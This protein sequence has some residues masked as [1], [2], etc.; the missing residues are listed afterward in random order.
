LNFEFLRTGAEVSFCARPIFEAALQDPGTN[1]GKV[2]KNMTE[3]TKEQKVKTER[4]K[5]KKIFKSL[6]PKA[7]QVLDGLIDNCAWM[8]IQLEDLRADLDENGTTELFQQSE[9]VDPYPRER[10]EA[11]QYI[12][13]SKNYESG[14]RALVS[15]LPKDQQANAL[16]DFQAFMARGR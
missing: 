10:P 11:A 4:N 12:K 16:D 1:R 2:V 15:N 3:K 8:R 5:L 7:M 9:K 6:D 14:I 13:I